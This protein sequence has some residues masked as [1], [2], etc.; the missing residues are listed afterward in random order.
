VAEVYASCQITVSLQSNTSVPARWDFDV[1][2][3]ILW[4]L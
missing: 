1:L 2:T 4:F 3:L